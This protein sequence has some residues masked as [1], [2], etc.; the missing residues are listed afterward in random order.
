M[1]GASLQRVHCGRQRRRGADCAPSHTHDHEQEDQHAD[2][3]V[4]EEEIELRWRKTPVDCSKAQRNLHE[5][6]SRNPSMLRLGEG[7]P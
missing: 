4:K 5:H 2:R 7:A 1:R 6:E 3:L